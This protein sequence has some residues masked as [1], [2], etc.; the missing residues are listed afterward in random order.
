MKTFIKQGSGNVFMFRC[1]YAEFSLR[2][3]YET[4]RKIWIISGLHIYKNNNYRKSNV[5]LRCVVIVK[6]S[7]FLEVTRGKKLSTFGRNLLPPSSGSNM[8]AVGSFETFVTLH[9]TT[10]CHVPEGSNFPIHR[11]RSYNFLR[12]VFSKR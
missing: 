9:Q 7:V 8:E 2:D 5:F 6:I 1:K 12:C 3:V 10:R 4:V 11:Q